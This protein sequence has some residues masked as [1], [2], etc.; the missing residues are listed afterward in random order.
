MPDSSFQMSFPTAPHVPIPHLDVNRD[1][2]NFVYAVA[3]L[4]P[5]GSYMAEGTTCS[6]TEYVR[7]WSE[8]TKVPA[9]YK[10]VSMEQFIELLGDAEFGRE[11]GDMFAYSSD[12]GY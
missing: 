1:T 4:P 7:I 6:W 2:G 8:V 12:P 11:V 3:K 9:S 10:Q 5:G